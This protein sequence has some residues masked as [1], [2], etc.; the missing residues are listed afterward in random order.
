[1]LAAFDVESSGP[2]PETDRI[3]TA[4]ISYVDG[5]GVLTPETRTWLINPGVDIPQG[6]T[7]VHGI[8]TEHARKH[9]QDPAEAVE[10]ISGE[11]VRAA[12]AGTPIVAFNVPFDFTML[13]RETRRHG[14]DPF[15]D[16]FEIVK[17][18]AVDGF[19]IDKA[20]DPYRPG[21]R[22]LTA[23]AAHYGVRQDAA[24]DAAGDAIT[25]ARVAWRIAS[26]RPEIARMTLTE[27]HA[28]Q[29]KEKR[30]WAASFRDYLRRQGRGDE[31]VDG[32]WP[33]RPWTGAEA[34]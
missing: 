17:G 4:C 19:V 20:I 3:V 13:D 16:E 22:T 30:K 1:M 2:E 29:V 28:W 31:P 8:T 12:A 26:T 32:S 24:H 14:L 27:L 25:A 18:V 6:A 23:V 10:E 7:D 15:G 9:G 21:K 11:L 5:S 34:A 33:L